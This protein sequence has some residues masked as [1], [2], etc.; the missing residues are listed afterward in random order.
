[1][2]ATADLIDARRSMNERRKP[3]Q[4][5]KCVGRA[6]RTDGR[7]SSIER[8][9]FSPKTPSRGGPQAAPPRGRPADA[10]NPH[11][12]GTPPVRCARRSAAVRRIIIILLLFYSDI[13]AGPICHTP[14]GRIPT[15]DVDQSTVADN[16]RAAHGYY[17]IIIIIIIM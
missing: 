9:A 16:A 13:R 4:L 2:I 1:M 8:S 5:C 11:R 3:L 12:R 6:D 7:R 17:N 15:P 10:F 14:S